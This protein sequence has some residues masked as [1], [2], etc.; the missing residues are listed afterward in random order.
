M[1]TLPSDV[2][3]LL[4]EGRI[5]VKGMIRFEF[6]TGTY[7]FVKSQAPLTYSGLE[8]KPGGLIAVSDLTNEMGLVAKQFT[9]TLAESPD[10][11]LTPAVLKTIEA[12]DYRDRPVKIFDAYFHPDTNALLFTQMMARGYVDTIKHVIT[13]DLGYAIV[14]NCESRALDYTRS[15]SR[16]R[17]DADQRRRDAD[18]AFFVNATKRGREQIYWA[19]ADPNSNPYMGL[20]AGT[21][22]NYQGSMK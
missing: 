2:L 1:I 15:N 5:T 12:E 4:D 21:M 13:G 18:D 10:D 9:I 7:G 22:D 14:A 17:S 8:Y 20:K 11:G 3:A 6:G 16:K 19:Q